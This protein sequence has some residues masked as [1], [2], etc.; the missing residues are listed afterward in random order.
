[1][2]REFTANT[3]RFALIAVGI[4]NGQVIQEKKAVKN[5]LNTEDKYNYKYSI[6]FIQIIVLKAMKVC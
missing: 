6:V 5:V 2:F 1:M 3:R 4:I